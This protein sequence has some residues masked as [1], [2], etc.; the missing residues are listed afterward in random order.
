MDVLC[1]QYL[2]TYCTYKPECPSQL[3]CIDQNVNERVSEYNTNKPSFQSLKMVSEFSEW[4]ID[5]ES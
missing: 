4:K 2:H 3:V 1:P 5:M